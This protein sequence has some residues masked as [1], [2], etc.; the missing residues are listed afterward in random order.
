MYRP[1]VSAPSSTHGATRLHGCLAQQKSCFISGFRT[2][3]QRQLKKR[4]KHVEKCLAQ[5][6][7]LSSQ[8]GFMSFPFGCCKHLKF[9]M[10]STNFTLFFLFLLD[11]SSLQ[12]FPLKSTS[13]QFCL[14]II[15]LCHLSLS[16]GVC[17]LFSP[18][19]WPTHT[20]ISYSIILSVIE[21]YY[22]T[23]VPGQCSHPHLK[24]NK[25]AKEDAFLAAIP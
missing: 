11:C 4:R 22:S 13:W 16:F 5:K 17:H 6:L 25:R 8:R 24:R 9:R 12:A 20:F 3:W 14:L 10:T 2:S 15:L 19:V 18:F 23:I 21:V 7:V 1:K